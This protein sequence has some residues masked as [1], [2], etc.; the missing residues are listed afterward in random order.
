MANVFMYSFLRVKLLREGREE[1]RVFL[2]NKL[3]KEH[4]PSLHNFS[5]LFVGV[6]YE[7]GFAVS[8][9]QVYCFGLVNCPAS[10]CC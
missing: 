2:R 6:C 7:T 4:L 1:L 3:H 10:F 8:S 9:E 5:L